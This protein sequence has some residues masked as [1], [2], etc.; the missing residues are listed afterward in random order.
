MST[1]FDA[2]YENPN[3]VQSKRLL[4]NYLLRKRAVARFLQGAESPILD[5]GSGIA[6]MV[7]RSEGAI[8]SDM[9]FP[10]MR[11]MRREGFDCC[12]LDIQRLGLKTGSVGTIICSEVLEHVPDDDQALGELARVLAPSG[13]LVVTVPLHRYYWA[14]DDETV[15]HL[16]RYDPAVLIGCLAKAGLH[17]EE[18]RS[19]G[20]ILERGLTLGAVL[21]FLRLNRKGAEW[22]RRPGALFA[23]TNR[24]VAA[25]LSILGSVS[26]MATSSIG[27]FQCR[28]T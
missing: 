27:L 5:I 21:M 16:R 4:F 1:A 6:P 15:G 12:L 3:Y 23:A 7:D 10:G 8:L 14:A 11:I 28:K 19:V 9:S 26:P 17:V 25:A 24:L 18:S 2:Y 20:S 22:R 13:R